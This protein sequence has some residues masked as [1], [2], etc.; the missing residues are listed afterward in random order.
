M[1]VEIENMIK[2]FPEKLKSTDTAITPSDK[3]LSIKVREGNY[4]KHNV[5]KYSIQRLLE[6]YSYVNSQD[7]IYS[8]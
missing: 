8:Q 7:Q 6:I 1:Q 3:G 5:L 4:Y 2:D